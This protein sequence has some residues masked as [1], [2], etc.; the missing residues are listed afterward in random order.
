[1]KL[2]T[3]SIVFYFLFYNLSLYCVIIISK[4]IREINMRAL[5][6][7]PGTGRCGFGIV[8]KKGN[9]ISA[10]DYG[11]IETTKEYSLS[12]RLNIIF[13]GVNELIEFYKPDVMGIETLYFN[14]NITTAIS[15]AQARGVIQLAG[16]QKNIKIFEC[17]PLQV[18]QQVV[19]YGR[20]EK[21]QVIEMIMQIMNIKKKISPDDAADALAIALTAIYRTEYENIYGRL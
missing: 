4:L 6:I 3:G 14:K 11:V 17:T 8:D 12:E 2:K 7:D 5:G 9:S 13:T 1:M 21:K 18:K 20:A 19:G 15:V 10:V 16:F